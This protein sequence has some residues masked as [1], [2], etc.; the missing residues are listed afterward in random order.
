[1]GALGMQHQIDG[2][3]SEGASLERLEA[4]VI[5][6]CGLHQDEQ[7]ALWLYA[8]CVADKPVRPDSDVRACAALFAGSD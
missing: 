2:L 7:S 3:L 5:D 4:E 8:W 1:M 6:R